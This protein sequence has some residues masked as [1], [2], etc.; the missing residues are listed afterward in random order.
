MIN[1]TAK[2]RLDSMFPAFAALAEILIV[3]ETIMYR[4]TKII[5]DIHG[6][7]ESRRK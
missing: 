3:Y 6:V 4:F 1:K 5:N 7:D 2:R